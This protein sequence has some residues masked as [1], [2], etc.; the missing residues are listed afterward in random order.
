MTYVTVKIKTEMSEAE[1]RQLVQDTDLRDSGMDAVD[2]DK[3]SAVDI[4]NLYTRGEFEAEL[5]EGEI[6]ERN[7]VAD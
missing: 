5:I 1:L 2:L 7:N 6:T 3:V 4:I